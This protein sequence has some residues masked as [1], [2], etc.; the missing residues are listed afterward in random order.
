MKMCIVI[1][2]LDAAGRGDQEI[3]Q[4]MILFGNASAGAPQQVWTQG[5]SLVFSGSGF[6]M[7]A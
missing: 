4:A 3:G 5:S 7:A 1:G 2:D 6:S